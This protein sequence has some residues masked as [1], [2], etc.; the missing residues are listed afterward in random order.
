MGRK[1]HLGTHRKNEERKKAN[2]RKKA[3]SVALSPH[4]DS[5]DDLTVSLPVE[6]YQKAPA[7]TLY[8]LQKRI[9]NAQSLPAGPPLCIMCV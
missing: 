6:N 3:L 8:S 4:Q 1:F 2:S 9:Q 5:G 7:P